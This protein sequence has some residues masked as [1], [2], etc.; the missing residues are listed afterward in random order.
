M[1]RRQLLQFSSLLP[2]SQSATSWSQ[3]GKSALPSRNIVVAQVVDFSQEQ[4]DVSKD[5]LASS[6]AAWLDINSRGGIRGKNVTH[7]APVPLV[8]ARLPLI[9]SYRETMSRLFDEP[10]TPLSL[11]GYIAARY[12]YDVLNDVD[13]ALTRRNVLTTFR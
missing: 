11:A 13:G 8:N 5:F 9:R 7:L 4:R 3:S 10:P 12:T 6:R 1:N 2:F